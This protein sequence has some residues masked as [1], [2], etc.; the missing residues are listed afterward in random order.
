MCI[1]DRPAVVLVDVELSVAVQVLK[2]QSVRLDEGVLGRGAQPRLVAALFDV[3]EAGCAFL[4]EGIFRQACQADH[5]DRHE[6][7]HEQ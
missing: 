4:D 2:G 6:Q 5:G 3:V 1:R 7:R